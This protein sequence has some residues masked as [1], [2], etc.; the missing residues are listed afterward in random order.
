MFRKAVENLKGRVRIEKEHSKADIHYIEQLQES[1]KD[2]LIYAVGTFHDERN[3]LEKRVE[4]ATKMNIA[5]KF[6]L[7]KS[8]EMLDES[9]KL[10]K[11]LIKYRD[12]KRIKCFK[13]KDMYHS[14]LLISETNR[15]INLMRGYT[16]QLTKYINNE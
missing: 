11:R 5:D 10:S 13:F 16:I 6:L 2:D 12:S 4:I 8:N 15:A 1:L 14:Y 7:T 9:I 3:I